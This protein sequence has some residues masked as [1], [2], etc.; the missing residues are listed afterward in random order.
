MS[1]PRLLPSP[2]DGI[3]ERIAD[4]IRERTALEPVAGIVLGSGLSG[5]VDAVKAA[6]T[7]GSVEISY[8]DL[9][10][11]PPPS[12][13]GHA[14]KLWL[15]QV[16]ERALAVF[17]G[18]IH[19]YEGHG[20]GMASITSRVAAEI[21]ARTMVLTAAA[22]ALDPTIDP[23]TLVVLRDH[24][25]MMGVNPLLGWRMPD[26]SPA[27]VDVSEVYDRELADRA[28]ASAR[29]FF[30]TRSEADAAGLPPPVRDG[31]Y[32]AVSGP[33]YETPAETRM[34]HLLGA[35]VVGMSTVPEAVAAR[36]LGM[37]V[38]G[39]AF[40][41]NAAGAPVSHAEVLVASKAA[42]DAI[43]RVLLDLV[44]AF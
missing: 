43:G 3:P 8:A 42:S 33:S 26:G 37:R 18:R 20:V 35:T 36:A 24:L 17:Q 38:L 13:V 39:L 44:E 19:F 7:S 15:G 4:A 32:V 28:L 23:G 9:P 6:A 1:E 30:E 34:L 41:T 31:V 12:V 5:A 16:G 22:G 11:F 21:G 2:G 10:G 14:G 25:N 27:F 40:A 29:G